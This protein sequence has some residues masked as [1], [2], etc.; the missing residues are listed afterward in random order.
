MQR[1]RRECF[2]ARVAAG[3][4]QRAL[5]SKTAARAEAQAAACSPRLG[6]GGGS[7]IPLS[8]WITRASSC[9]SSCRIVLGIHHLLSEGSVRPGLARPSSVHFASGALFTKLL[10]QVSSVPLRFFGELLPMFLGC[11]LPRALRGDLRGTSVQR[12]LVQISSGRR[13]G[14]LLLNSRCCRQRMVL[15][16]LAVP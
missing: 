8:L 9:S 4:L 7:R 3:A 15:A 5:C 2:A 13:R 10:I 11:G 6:Q 1:N 16:S 14:R 12:S